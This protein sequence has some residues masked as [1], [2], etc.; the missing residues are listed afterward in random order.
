MPT[1]FYK[2][3]RKCKCGYVTL[4]INNWYQ[5][6]KICKSIPSDKDLMI[7]QM[8]EQLAAKDEQIKELIEVAKKQ[9]TVNNNSHNTTNNNRFMVENHINVFG[10][11][12]T[13]HITPKQIQQLLSDPVN[14]VPHFI[15][16]KYRRAHEF[17][18]HHLRR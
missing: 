5:H 1:R 11:E 14:A 2:E 10:K 17:F 4:N 7:E 6:K 9:K 12:N 3:E 16:L 15:T 8:K 13:D 18:R